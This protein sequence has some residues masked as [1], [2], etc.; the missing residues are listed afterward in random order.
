LKRTTGLFLSACALLL[1]RGAL[2]GAEE[3]SGTLTDSSGQP[4]TGA[5]VKVS[6]RELNIGFAV[7]TQTQGRYSTPELQPGSYVVQAFGPDSESAALGPITIAKGQPPKI[8]LV[9]SSPLKRT[10][11]LKRFSDAEFTKLM[12]DG[13]GKS[14]VSS[15]CAT[16]HGLLWVVSARKTP[17]KWAE[18]V[19][20]MRDDLQGRD[21]PLNDILGESDLLQLD[22]MA[23]Y[24]AKNFTPETPVDPRVVEQW[25]LYPGAPGHPNRNLP[26]T[27]LA[28]AASKYVGMEFSLAS[29]AAPH[30]IAV[31]SEGNA[32]VTES[33]TGMLGRFDPNS[34]TY[35]RIRVPPGKN[36]KLQLN[37][38]AVDPSGQIWFV[39]DG[40]NARMLKY[41]AKTKEFD[42]Y[43]I[44]QYKYPIPPDFTPARLMTLR[45]LNGDVWGTGLVA[46]WLVKVD[47]KSKQVTEYPVPK[48]SAPYGLAIGG[49]HRVWYA[50]EV[51]NLVGKLDPANQRVTSYTVPTARS[52]VRG[53]A[54]D[55]DG[56]LWVAATES[57]KLLRV[58]YTNGNF[59]EFPIPNADSGPF[60]VDVDTKNN[61]IWFSEVYADKLAQFD[62]K[63]K[64]FVEFPLPSSDMDVRSIQVDPHNPR[65]VWWAGGRAGKIGYIEATE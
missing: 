16:C 58:D 63:S 12:P 4:V 51:G 44:P 52:D 13:P 38:V 5:L 18:T 48:G 62:P 41:S 6:S 14:S 2:L 28:G 29:N 43:S 15:R 33:N 60:A 45:F 46:N 40:P 31:D 59:T 22:E 26:G 19:D 32:W 50:A 17:E 37:A 11:L 57:G 35:S 21:R 54:A 25:Q 55:S 1:M 56:N 7:V 30:D 64:T 24:L 53:M 61:L 49:D 42:S 34:M 10:P 39:D 20:R 65:R 47:P 9:L 27:L 23:E 8:N 3:L 36:G